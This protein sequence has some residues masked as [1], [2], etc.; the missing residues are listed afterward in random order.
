MK[1]IKS[2]FSYIK[3][4]E[5]YCAFCIHIQLIKS[6]ICC[7]TQWFYIFVC[8]YLPYLPIPLFCILSLLALAFII[9]MLLASLNS[10]CNPWIYMFFAG[11]LFRDLMERCVMT[12]HCGCKKQWRSRKHSGTGAMRRNSSQKSVT[13]TS[14]TWY[15]TW[16]MEPSWRQ[17]QNNIS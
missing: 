14:T 9:A 15:C 1:R 13:Q 4:K 12:S 11:H 16:N 6:N 17:L 5:L 8:V 2:Q 3:L 10:C 7:S